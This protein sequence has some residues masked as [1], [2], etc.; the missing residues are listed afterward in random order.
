[1]L[2]NLT[3]LKFL[4]IIYFVITPLF[5]LALLYHTP[6]PMHINMEILIQFNYTLETARLFLDS[7]I[8]DIKCIESIN[9]LLLQTMSGIIAF[10]ASNLNQKGAGPNKLLK[11][12]PYFRISHSCTGSYAVSPVRWEIERKSTGATVPDGWSTS[13]LNSAHLLRSEGLTAL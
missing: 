8:G 5:I 7:S 1:M 6:V 4:F 13:L 2:V 10:Q 9:S 3:L 12:Y 11:A